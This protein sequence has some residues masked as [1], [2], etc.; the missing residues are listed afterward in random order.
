MLSTTERC[1]SFQANP[2]MPMRP[3]RHKIT[4]SSFLIIAWLILWVTTVP[5]FHTHL[6][7]TTDAPASMQGGLAHTVFSPDLPGEFSRSYNVTHQQHFFHL[8]NRVSNS[9]ELSLA[10]L[11]DDEKY[12]KIGQPS[13][14]TALCDVPTSSLVPHSTIESAAIPPRCFLFMAPHGPRPPPSAISL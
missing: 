9:P 4:P 12:R 13:V 7:D 14:L 10:L 6:P 2:Q 11:D 5:L 8:S 1:V 3:F